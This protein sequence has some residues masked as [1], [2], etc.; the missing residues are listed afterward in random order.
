MMVVVT[1]DS[2]HLLDAYNS[3]Q[4]EDQVWLEYWA[5]F[6]L[7]LNIGIGLY[8]STSSNINISIGKQSII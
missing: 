1:N 3:V 5:K 2:E 4:L 7:M 8:K 6:Y